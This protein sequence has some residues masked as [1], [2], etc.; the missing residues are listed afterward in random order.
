VNTSVDFF[1]AIVT[2]ASVVLF[3]KFVTHRTRNREVVTVGLHW[4]HVGCVVLSI[5]AIALALIGLG[6]ERNP[7]SWLHILSATVAAVA[8]A[9]LVI[10]GLGDDNTRR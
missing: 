1:N 7:P 3:A 5:V 6:R 4:W 2:L 8:V 10:D 9:I